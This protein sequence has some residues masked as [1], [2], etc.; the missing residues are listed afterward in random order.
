MTYLYR[1]KS[2]VDL[3]GKVSGDYFDEIS[4]NSYI[5]PSELG[6]YNS[7]V[8][9]FTPSS[10]KELIYNFVLTP[11]STYSL[12]FTVISGYL[13]QEYNNTISNVIATAEAVSAI[14]KGNA[15]LYSSSNKTGVQLTVPRDID[16]Q[17][18]W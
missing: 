7:E 3:T 8:I 6:T 13:N 10:G 18:C 17:K 11:D 12:G 9:T 5:T 1:T 4:D 2:N 14:K 15:T 16:D